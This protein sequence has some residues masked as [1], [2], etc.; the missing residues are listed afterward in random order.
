MEITLQL[1]C[2][3]IF[4]F[5]VSFITSKLC[6]ECFCYNKVFLLKSQLRYLLS[7][8]YVIYLFNVVMFYRDVRLT[9]YFGT[10]ELRTILLYKM[11]FF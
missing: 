9:L 1:C 3:L 5:T 2:A 6:Y 10:P 8:S 7:P 4:Y 11:A